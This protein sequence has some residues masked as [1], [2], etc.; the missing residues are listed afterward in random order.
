MLYGSALVIG[1]I[2]GTQGY[3]EHI[4]SYIFLIGGTLLMINSIFIS[5][6]I[7]KFPEEF[8]REMERRDRDE[9]SSKNL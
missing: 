9:Q 4:L 6:V 7:N 1:T 8:E 2:I 5:Y 3:L